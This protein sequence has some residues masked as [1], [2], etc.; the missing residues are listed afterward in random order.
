MLFGST[1]QF[2]VEAE[3]APSDAQAVVRRLRLKERDG[4]VDG[5]LLVVRD[6]R[7]VRDF[8]ASGDEFFRPTFPTSARSA[9]G[10]LRAGAKPAGNAII[11]VGYGP[12]PAT[13]RSAPAS[14]S[15][16]R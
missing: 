8:F 14:P 1:W 12:R 7:R 3:T 13:P 5:M 10:S 4:R 16:P 2:G 6:T 15:L 11:V 9:L